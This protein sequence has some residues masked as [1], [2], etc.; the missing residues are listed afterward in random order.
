[1]K[2]L[3]LYSL[4]E[5]GITNVCFAISNRIPPARS[6]QPLWA[7]VLIMQILS[8]LL[9]VLHV[10]PA[11]DRHQSHLQTLEGSRAQ[12]LTSSLAATSLTGQKFWLD[13]IR[14]Y[15]S[16][17]NQRYS[18][19]HGAQL[20]EVIVLRILHLYYTPG[21]QTTTDLLTLHFDKLVGAND[22]KGNACLGKEVKC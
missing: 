22:S 13:F 5:T 15:F 16:N 1:M 14:L 9:E 17:Y 10:G 11:T 7:E 2:W 19:K 8:Y 4:N 20:Q 3:I 12:I 21:V 18:H 6:L